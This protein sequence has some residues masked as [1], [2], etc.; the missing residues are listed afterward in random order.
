M[1]KQNIEATIELVFK[2]L[3]GKEI[4]SKA[5]HLMSDK[6]A[7]ALVDFLYFFERLENLLGVP[8]LQILEGQDF[9]CMTVENLAVRYLNAT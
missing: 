8:T 4:Q 7:I 2:D 1:Q 6:Y 9:R 3:T 5:D